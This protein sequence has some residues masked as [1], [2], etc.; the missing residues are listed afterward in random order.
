[1]TGPGH[2]F[3]EIHTKMPKVL[4]W[5]MNSSSKTRS[6]HDQTLVEVH[7]LSRSELRTQKSTQRL[8]PLSD[9]NPGNRYTFSIIRFIEHQSRNLPFEHPLWKHPDIFLPFFQRHFNT[10]RKYPN[11]V[12]C[13]YLN[14]G[15]HVLFYSYIGKIK[16]SGA[17]LTDLLSCRWGWV[18]TRH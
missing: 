15:L 3:E 9:T 7:T 10:W 17:F 12:R 8:L 18:L 4:I 14:C 13:T 1:M 11:I 6:W 16:F 2:G 5:Q